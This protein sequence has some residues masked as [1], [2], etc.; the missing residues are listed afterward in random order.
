M[1]TNPFFEDCGEEQKPDPLWKKEWV[2]MP[3]FV[4]EKQEPY[5]QIIVR[6]NSEEDL[7]DFAKLIGQKLT[8]KT[9]SIWHPK[10]VKRIR[11]RWVDE[12]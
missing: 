2:G 3:E 6:F 1:T 4:Q 7:Q 9:K 5:S 12:S 10:Y 11:G 8:N